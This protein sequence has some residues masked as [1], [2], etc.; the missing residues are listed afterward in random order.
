M[1]FLVF[2]SR[3]AREREREGGMASPSTVVVAPP[4][5]TLPSV[6]ADHEPSALSYVK[7]ETNPLFQ[8][9]RVSAPV[10]A[11]LLM[12][13]KDVE[14]Q[15]QQQQKDNEQQSEEKQQQRTKRLRNITMRNDALGD[16]RK[17]MQMTA[18]VN[19]CASWH[20]HSFLFF[21]SYCKRCLPRKRRLCRRCAH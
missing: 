14:Q 21:S 5:A 12:R 16:T 3:R 15:Q 20:S 17:G 7:E 4:A 18:F 2:F 6:M 13:K 8:G 1:V 9:T 10:L 11:V 19:V